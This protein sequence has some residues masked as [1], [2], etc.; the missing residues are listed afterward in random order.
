[1]SDGNDLDLVGQETINDVKW[2]VE[3]HEAPPCVAG[4]R[5]PFWSFRDA[6]DCVLHLPDQ[7]SG[8]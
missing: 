4:E 6:G 7:T 5:V 2:V 1:M 8:R 3:E